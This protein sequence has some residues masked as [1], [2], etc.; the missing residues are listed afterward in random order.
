MAPGSFYA[1][2][3]TLLDP[4]AGCKPRS[5]SPSSHPR[6]ARLTASLNKGG[7]LVGRTEASRTSSP[8]VGFAASFP[9]GGG[10]P[11]VGRRTCVSRQRLWSLHLFRL[12]A[13]KGSRLARAPCLPSREGRWIFAHR[14]KRRKGRPFPGQTSRL[15]GSIPH[16]P[17]VPRGPRRAGSCSCGTDC[18][19]FNSFLGIRRM[20]SQD[21]QN[22]L[23]RP[24]PGRTVRFAHKAARSTPF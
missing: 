9:A 4:G 24:A 11:L 1:R 17:L 12:S 20:D 5:A 22:R 2:D 14:A 6:A 10:K 3:G 16:P 21:G 7:L 18:R 23:R 8:S 19:P 15:P 13:V